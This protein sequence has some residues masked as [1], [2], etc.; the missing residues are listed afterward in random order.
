MFD[1]PDVTRQLIDDRHDRWQREAA[2]RRVTGPA[3]R[4]LRVWIR[5][6]RVSFFA[7][8]RLTARDAKPATT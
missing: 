8:R 3:P 2:A 5:T 4:K 1:N 7:R 6:P